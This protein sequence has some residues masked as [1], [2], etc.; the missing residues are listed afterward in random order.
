SSTD[1]ARRVLLGTNSDRK[2][3]KAGSFIARSMRRGSTNLR[4]SPMPLSRAFLLPV[5]LWARHRSARR[6]RRSRRP[7]LA[8]ARG[9]PTHG[10]SPSRGILPAGHGHSQEAVSHLGTNRSS[11]GGR[12]VGDVSTRGVLDRIAQA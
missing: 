1:R 6:R 3:V 8:G 2:F 10:S 11:S 9:S 4:Y 5:R 12:S 7:A